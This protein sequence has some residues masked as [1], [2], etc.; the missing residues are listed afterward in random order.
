MGLKFICCETELYKLV[1]LKSDQNGI[2]ITLWRRCTQLTPSLKSD[3]N[4]IEIYKF[5]PVN[6]E[7][8]C[9]KIRPK[10]DWNGSIVANRYSSPQL[11]SD[12]NGIE[13]VLMVWYSWRGLNVKIRP[14]WD[15]NEGMSIEVLLHEYVKIR[16][17]W[18]WNNADNAIWRLLG[19][20]KIRPKWDWNSSMGLW[21]SF[22]VLLLKSDQ[23]GIEIR[24]WVYGLPSLSFC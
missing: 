21:T 13:M 18:D 19:P 3:Q 8:V 1:R 11:K 7:I 17:K 22:T 20:V 15:W 2:E 5:T 12:Q 6:V 16:P 10:W 9:V 23:N 24:V 14:K 4:G